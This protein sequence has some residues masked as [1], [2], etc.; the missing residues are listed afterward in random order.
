[1]KSLIKIKFTVYLLV[2][3]TRNVFAQE[4][5]MVLAAMEVVYGAV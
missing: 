1:M 3:L 5:L 2:T 4:F